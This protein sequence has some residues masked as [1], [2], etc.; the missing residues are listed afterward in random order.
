MLGRKNALYAASDT[1]TPKPHLQLCE[2]YD[3]STS[4]NNQEHIFKSVTQLDG[5]VRVV[6]ATTAFGMGLDNPNVRTV[7]HWR[8]PRHVDMYSMFRKQEEEERWKIDECCAVFFT[9]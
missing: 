8:A 7:I 4:S 1:K 6:V 5:V 3:G 2:K 9:P